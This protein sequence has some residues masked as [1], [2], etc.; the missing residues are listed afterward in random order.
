MAK[1]WSPNRS[2][3]LSNHPSGIKVKESGDDD[4][5]IGGAD[6]FTAK[7]GSS[8]D[9][10]YRAATGKL[11]L[12]A[13]ALSAHDSINIGPGGNMCGVVTA[14]DSRNK[15]AA[16]LLAT[17]TA[18]PGAQTRNAVQAL[19]GN[20]SPERQLADEINACPKFS[21]MGLPGKSRGWFTGTRL[22]LNRWLLGSDTN[23]GYFNDQLWIKSP[24]YHLKANTVS[25]NQVA[26]WLEGQ[27]IDNRE[28]REHAVL[29]TIVITYGAAAAG[30]GSRS[31]VTWDAGDPEYWLNQRRPPAVALAHELLH[32]YFNLK[33]L[34]PGVEDGHFSTVLFEYRCVGI[35]PWDEQ[36][37]S[38]NTIRREWRDAALPHTAEG[39]LDHRVCPKRITYD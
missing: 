33:G 19:F 3:R 15:V 10:I 29:A 25:A 28:I 14:S 22:A 26:K 34:Q 31:W 12:D 9:L 32:A 21:I 18:V 5:P 37:P 38:E 2:P 35:G 24:G 8:L 16:E 7:A 17:D 20:N 36:T 6:D 39:D 11:V 4:F 23:E 1:Y 27:H 30:D 13:L